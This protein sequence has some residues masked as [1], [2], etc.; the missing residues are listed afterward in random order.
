[1]CDWLFENISD[2]LFENIC[3]LLFE[4]VCDLLFENR[5]KVCGTDLDQRGVVRQ[6]AQ[7]RAVVAIREN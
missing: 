5:Q 1:M 4:N 2:L 6:A 7:S 3:D